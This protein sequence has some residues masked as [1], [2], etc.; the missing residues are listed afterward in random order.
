[1]GQVISIQSDLTDGAHELCRPPDSW[2]DKGALEFRDVFMR[3]RKGLDP[4]LKGVSFTIA[5][6]EKVRITPACKL[7]TDCRHD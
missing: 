6:G 5:A 4:V 3:Y 7:F 1:M 2:P